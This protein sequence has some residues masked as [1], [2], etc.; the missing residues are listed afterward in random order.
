[1]SPRPEMAHRRRPE[2]LAAASEVI[3]ERGVE[4]TRIVDVADRLGNTPPAVLY[5][6]DSKSE[7][8]S[9]ALITTEEEFYEEFEQ[10][11]ERQADAREALALLVDAC[12]G[13]DGDNDASLWIELWSRALREPE[14]GR[15]RTELDARW[16]DTI[17]R[18]V[19]QGQEDGEF[20]PADPDDVGTMLG[21]LLDGFS[22]QVTL[23]DAAVPVARARRLCREL[24]ERELECELPESSD[25]AA[26]M[27]G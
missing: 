2:I 21:S 1:M 4:G 19:R 20:G 10:R 11:L 27:A 15:M 23:G 17:G 6:F 18:I 26:V 5:Y 14:L 24:L 22:I 7:L 16:R 13:D 12:L 8:L 9:T 25:S 3:R